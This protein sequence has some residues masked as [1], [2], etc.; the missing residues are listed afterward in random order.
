MKSMMIIFPY[1]HDL[2]LSV[3]FFLYYSDFSIKYNEFLAEN[4]LPIMNR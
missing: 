3:L 2:N 4:F 1:L